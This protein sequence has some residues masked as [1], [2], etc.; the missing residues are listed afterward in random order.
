MVDMARKEILPAV[1]RYA[2]QLSATVLS[3]KSVC[4]ELD[5][6]YEADTLT[7]ISSLTA[8]AYKQALSLEKALTVTKKIDGVAKLS[9]YYR[10]KVI[11]IMEK[12]RKAADELEGLVAADFWP[13]PTY[14]DLL[15]G[16]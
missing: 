12:L 9:V 6:S 13:M 3:K 7:K 2:Q 4:A 11:P 16:I 15:F 5:C 1:S 8:D 10:D 14:G